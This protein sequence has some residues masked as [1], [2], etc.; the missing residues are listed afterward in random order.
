MSG[1]VSNASEPVLAA[2]DEPQRCEIELTAGRAAKV[3]A[4]PVKRLVP[5]RTRRT[6]GPWCFVDHMGPAPV[7]DTVGLD[8]APHPHIG[9]QTVTW[10]LA[11]QILHRDSL[12]SEQLIRPG[13]L[14]LMTA[15]DGVAHS[16]ETRGIYTGEVHGVQLWVAQPEAT[17]KGAP[18]FEHHADLPRFDTGSGTGTVMVGSL[19]RTRSPARCDTD[20]VAVELALRAGRSVFP[21]EH[22]HEYALV[23]L[24]GSAFVDGVELAPGR[25]GYLGIGRDEL[26]I[27]A[28]GT[29]RALLIGGVPLPDE[30]VMWWNYVARSR[31][32]ITAAHR[33]WTEDDGRFGEVASDLSRIVVDPPP[34]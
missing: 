10:L 25:L 14:N 20:H 21:L 28:T 17:R 22:H 31:D 13:Q 8:V 1:P 18:G 12:G 33:A 26:A 6:V 11:G 5:R 7:S 4:M 34:W 32:E 30:L 16:E 24:D 15:G 2:S 19:A 29:A 23:V 27:S 9:L 3:G